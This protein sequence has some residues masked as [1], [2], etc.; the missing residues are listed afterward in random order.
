MTATLRLSRTWGSFVTDRGNDWQVI[1]DGIV[2][3]SVGKRQTVEIPVE[4]GRHRLRVRSSPRFAS[5]ER[6][7]EAGDE[8]VVSFHCHSQRYWPL[9]LASLIKPDL[10]IT[11]RRE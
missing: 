4:P 7:F 5:S 3:G 11:L 9:I 10:W 2:A 6:S 1:V 8:H